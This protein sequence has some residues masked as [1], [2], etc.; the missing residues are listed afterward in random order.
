MSVRVLIVDD[1]SF[2]RRRVADMLSSDARFVVVGFG[3]DGNDAIKK[4]QELK[5][6]VIV[7]DVEMPVMDGITAVRRIMA[8]QPT[9]I[10]MFSSL[11]REG[12]QATFE[13]LDAGAVD[14]LPKNFEEISKTPDEVGRILRTRVWGIGVRGVNKPCKEPRVGVETL[15]KTVAAEAVATK[16]KT[17]YPILEAHNEIELVV[18]AASTGGPVAVQQIVQNLPAEFPIPILLIQHMPA[19]FTAAFA[20]RLNSICSI[21]V[22]EA[23]DGDVL[24]PGTALLAP[25]G[26]QMVLAGAQGHYHVR[27]KAATPD[28]NY[29]PCI[30]TTLNSI[31]EIFHG[32]CLVIVLT[33]MGADG[34][35]G[36]RVLKRKRAVIW[37]QD[38][39]SSVIYG[40]PMAVTKAGL[41]DR[42]LALVEIAPALLKV[43]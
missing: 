4:V 19:S 8:V 41:A 14:F 1:S 33:G 42:E 40:M 13:A 21:D 25:G 2:F 3:V 39:A 22:K 30:D 11:T 17:A 24:K 43:T 7:M 34:R 37:A 5:P 35:E 12:A 27:I 15:R 38:E 28:Q 23:T 9:P 10:L 31:A 16:P 18:I 36:A 26:K 20:E 32:K 29:K 6:D